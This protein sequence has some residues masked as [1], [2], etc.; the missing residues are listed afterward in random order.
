MGQLLYKC[1]YEVA[2]VPIRLI[3]QNTNKTN[4]GHKI[5]KQFVLSTE[6]NYWTSY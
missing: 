5:N 4:V 2:D 6:I 1:D 3:E